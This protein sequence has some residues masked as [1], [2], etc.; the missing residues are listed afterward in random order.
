[1]AK[2]INQTGR[3]YN[4]PPR[5]RGAEE[6]KNLALGP[7]R[8]LDVPDWYFEEIKREK[9]WGRRLGA[10]NVV[11]GPKLGSIDAVGAARQQVNDATERARSADTAR[12]V[13]EADKARSEAQL[14]ELARAKA[15]SDAKA[16]ALEAELAALRA[17]GAKKDPKKDPKKDEADK[18]RSEAKKDG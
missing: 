6:V 1:M 11:T 3:T 13:A 2:L 9:E 8:T 15:Q 17:E 5:K 12:R 4:L 16:E 14:E 10:G 7:G 18:A